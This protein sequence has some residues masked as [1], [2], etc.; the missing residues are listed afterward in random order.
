MLSLKAIGSSSSEVGY[1]ARLGSEDYYVKGGEPPG[2]WWGSGAES[3]GLSG[4]V[5]GPELG[6]LLRGFS[7]D[8]RKSLVQN[9][10][11]PKRRSA[12]DLT[13]TVP[14]SVSVAWSQESLEGRLAIERAGEAALSHVLE[15]VQHL[16]GVTRRG[17]GGS[18]VETAK[19]AAGIFRHETARAVQGE[20]PDPNL[21]WHVVL[22]NLSVREDGTTG[23]L[24]GRALFT[25][26]MKM[27]LGALFRS[28]L[29]KELTAIGFSCYRPQRNGKEASWFE[30]DAV[31]QEMLDA[32][33]KRR[34]EIK[35]WLE[36]RGLSGAKAAERAANKT[37]HAKTEIVRDD[38]LVAWKDAGEQ[39]GYR[40][41]SHTPDGLLKPEVNTKAD[42]K[43]VV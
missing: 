27:A 38:L 16:C 7:R 33:S 6:N 10:G 3:L 30:I 43:S 32:F 8:G 42:R 18:H 34:K 28:E 14:K 31:P 24:D 12:F 17:H 21:H 36:E 39:L 23:S 26:H 1:Y 25:P 19:L 37:K 2:V 29:A 22:L 13:W 15:V 9:A 41:R 40:G 35:T 11:K 20:T 5:S 4:Q